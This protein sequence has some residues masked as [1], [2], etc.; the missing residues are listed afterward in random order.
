LGQARLV[1]RVRARGLQQRNDGN[2]TG[3]F[4]VAQYNSATSLFLRGS[5]PLRWLLDQAC[6]R[7]RAAQAPPLHQTRGCEFAVAQNNS[8]IS[9]FL[10]AVG[11]LCW[12]L[13]QARRKT[14][15]R[16]KHRPYIRRQAANLPSHK[17]T[18]RS[19]SSSGLRG[20]CVG[21]WARPGARQAGGASTAPTPMA[22]PS[23]IS[24]IR[25]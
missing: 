20:L 14:G 21:S 11:P 1:R 4:T 7:Q 16:R 10:R 6:A 5:G 15:G 23:P 17:T 3:E 18:R 13:G 8:A 9:F 25:R 19:P 12:K 2:K 22:P 24:S